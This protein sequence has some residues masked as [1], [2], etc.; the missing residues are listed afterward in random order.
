MF[1]SDADE[2]I[3]KEV[4]SV[5]AR[6]VI[7]D[8]LEGGPKT[9]SEIRD[10]IRKDMAAQTVRTKGRK[11]LNPEDFVVTDPKLYFNTKHLENLGII[12]SS[13]VSQ[14][15][16]FRLE[17]KAIHPVRR[18][19]GVSRR[20]TYLTSL[21][22]P[23]DQRLFISWISRS[24]DFKL[25]TLHLFVEKEV[26]KSAS[27]NLDRYIPDGTKMKWEG[28][29][30]ELGEDIV[31]NPSTSGRA[32]LKATYNAIEAVMLDHIE[33]NDIVIDVTQGSQLITLAL[34]LLAT[35][36]SLKTIHVERTSSEEA[37]ITQVLPR[38]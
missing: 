13:K 37:I 6:R 23:R 33:D 14:Q 25:D 32:N 31:G 35:D 1:W 38:R 11:K 5:R 7:L 36:Y 22:Q 12:S 26:F 19:L 4:E 30:N 9:G 18:A 27:K 17:P 3:R 24:R 28:H 29:W 10:S 21:G 8:Q 16:V 2:V 34:T 15:R 20:V